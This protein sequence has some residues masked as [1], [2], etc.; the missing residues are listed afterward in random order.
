MVHSSRARESMQMH[1]FVEVL[2]LLAARLVRVF[3]LI[4]AAIPALAAPPNATVVEFYRSDIDHYF[5]TASPFEQAVLDEGMYGGWTRTGRTFLAW[6][7]PALAPPTARPVC[8]FLGRPRLDSHFHTAFSNECSYV[9]QRLPDA[10]LLESSGAFFVEAPETS[11]SCS[12]GTDPVYRVYNNDPA[13]ANHRYVTA[14]DDRT[15]MLSR[16]WIAEGYGAIGVAL[17][18][19]R[20]LTSASDVAYA[21]PT[22]Y[23]S[24]PGASLA[25]ADEAEAV[26]H[27]TITLQD[28]QIPYTA[29]AGHLVARDPQS[30]QAQASM[31]YVA[32]AAQG[33]DAATRPITFFFNGGP[34]SATVWL[35]LGSYG[36]KRL[37][38]GGPSVALQRPYALVH[39]DESLLDATDMVFVDAVGAGLSQAIAPFNNQSWWSVEQDAR[40]FRNFIVRYLERYGREAS[41]KFIFGESYGGVRAAVLANLLETAGVTLSGVVFQ[42]PVLDYNANCGV[43]NAMISCAGYLPTYAAVG[44]HYGLVDRGSLD[45]GAFL[46]EVRT[47][48]IDAYDPAIQNFLAASTLPEAS[49]LE[50]LVRA[51][52]LGQSEWESRF[53]YDPGTFQRRLVPNTVLGRYDARVSARVGNP[54]ASGGDPSS[55]LIASS[56]IGA[57]QPHLAALKYS[58]ASPYT[59]L[60]NAIQT[61]D[62]SYAGR[63][64]PDTV[65]DLAAALAQNPQLV[66]LSLSGYHD[67]ATPFFVTERDLARLGPLPNVAVRNYD[68][69]HMTYLDD[70]SRRL[71][72][73][74]LVAMYRRSLIALATGTGSQ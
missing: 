24:T 60:G 53:N 18:V 41:P 70:N 64:L 20:P 65:P 33:R 66:V 27:H 48:A 40:I 31:F 50:V 49:V 68:G 74:D 35:H 59:T 44:T 1:S 21:D 32:Y 3:T 55:S 19:P 11:G 2:S 67:L 43:T 12:D 29:T 6:T 42:S 62:F 34:G 63:V 39:N 61:W 7:D 25:F 8:R 54:L 71:G 26:S 73:A 17:C 13:D 38:T 9:S 46:A 15:Q 51:T 37:A 69:G 22:T 16:G 58:Y 47:F 5:I 14:L 30:L 56:F 72:R 28:T 10:W 36:P 52:G 4:G 57:I 45:Q 23:S